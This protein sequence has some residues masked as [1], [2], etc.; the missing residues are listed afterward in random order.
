MKPTTRDVIAATAAEWGITPEDITGPKRLR[1]YAWPRQMAMAICCRML[2]GSHADVGRRFN[3]DHTTVIHGLRAHDKRMGTHS[4]YRRSYER[5]EEAV[6]RWNYAMNV[7]QG[8]GGRLTL[9]EF[10]SVR[11]AV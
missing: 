11:G 10:K 6:S 2:G 7:F 1:I 8:A 9:P 5:I 3:R 4:S